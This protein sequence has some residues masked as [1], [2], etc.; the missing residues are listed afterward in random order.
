MKTRAR[1]PMRSKGAQARCTYAMERAMS[2][3]FP[4]SAIGRS[5]TWVTGPEALCPQ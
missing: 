5:L 3:P 1:P 2:V 4:G